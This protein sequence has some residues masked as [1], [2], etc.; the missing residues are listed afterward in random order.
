MLKLC[1]ILMV[2]LVPVCA[3]SEQIYGNTY[4]S[5]TGGT[6]TYFSNSDGSS[7]T[8]NVDRRGNFDIYTTPSTAQSI[9][10]RKQA[11][12]GLDQAVRELNGD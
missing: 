12:E 8:V 4:P 10:E 9:G 6:T 5:I 7:A 11:Q 2:L 1:V 3:F